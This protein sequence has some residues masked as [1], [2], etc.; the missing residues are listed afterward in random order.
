M[1][2]RIDT[3]NEILDRANRRETFDEFFDE[4]PNLYLLFTIFRFF[5]NNKE[6]STRQQ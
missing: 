5:R 4:L 2:H 3:K 1:I 6:V